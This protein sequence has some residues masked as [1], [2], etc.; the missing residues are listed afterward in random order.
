MKAAERAIT[1]RSGKAAVESIA[2]G[3]KEFPLPASMEKK[4]READIAIVRAG[5]HDSVIVRIAAVRRRRDALVLKFG[6]V[7]Q[8]C[9]SDI[10][11]AP[12]SRRQIAIIKS[13]GIYSRDEATQ[14]I[15]RVLR[16][17]REQLGRASIKQLRDWANAPA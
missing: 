6:D 13:F 14:N 17:A 3:V 1:I 15:G 2:A 10:D 12:L 11:L 5:N 7:L 4:A 16:G 9:H 8:R